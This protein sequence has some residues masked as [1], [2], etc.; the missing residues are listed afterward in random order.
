MLENAVQ[1]SVPVFGM[2]TTIIFYLGQ[3]SLAP[4]GYRRE[5]FEKGWQFL[6]HV[7]CSGARALPDFGRQSAPPHEAHIR[8]K[9]IPLTLYLTRIVQIW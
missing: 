9:P 1:K 4:F 8:V 2:S 3:Y 5:I 6:L 7:N